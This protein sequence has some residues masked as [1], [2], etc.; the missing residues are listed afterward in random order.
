MKPILRRL[1]LLTLLVFF[2]SAQACGNEPS[3]Q[4]DP[5]MA[6]EPLSFLA[7][8]DSYTIGESV[9]SAFRWPVQLAKALGRETDAQTVALSHARIEAAAVPQ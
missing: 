1:L 5:V 6:S 7:L 3:R 9:D 8:G 4:V 2:C